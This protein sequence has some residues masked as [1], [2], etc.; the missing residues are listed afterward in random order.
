MN[1]QNEYNPVPPVIPP[2]LKAG[3]ST[4][5]KLGDNP[6]D[7]IPVTG[8]LSAFDALLRQP[9]RVL[10]HLTQPRSAKLIAAMLSIAIACSLIYGVVVGTFSGG[11]QLWAA[12]MKITI[13]LLISALICLPSLY[14]FACLSGSQ[15]RLVEVAGLVG[16]LLALMTVLLIG[17]AP[18]AWVF[19][20]STESVVA[21]GALHLVF[22][23][24]ATYFGLRFLNHG[25]SQL[26]NGFKGGLK[27]WVVIFLL[28]MVQMA[29]AL[30][31]IVGT[32]ETLLPREK[33]FFL[34]HWSD[35]WKDSERSHHSLLERE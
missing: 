26:S 1:P 19:S 4:T 29:T 17:F 22:W 2:P 20:Q 18:V 5:T 24:I 6:S 11:V 32:A 23:L 30:R 12:P 10:F 3:Q 28:V 21:M 13:G 25:F 35:C 15:A 14:I 16:G 8:I 9:R 27:G 7:H 34:T 33:K 31:P